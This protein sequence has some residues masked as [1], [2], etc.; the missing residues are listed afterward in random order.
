MKTVVFKYSI[1]IVKPT[2]FSFIKNLYIYVK[3]KLRLIDLNE[4]TIIKLIN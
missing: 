3:I 4:F 1:F 2:N